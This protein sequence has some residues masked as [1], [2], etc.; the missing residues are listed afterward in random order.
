MLR[1]RKIEGGEMTF[2]P[3]FF[4]WHPAGKLKNGLK[5]Y[6]M[7]VECKETFPKNSVLAKSSSGMDS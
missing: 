3:A 2:G 6:C 7:L 1:C 5:E 4:E